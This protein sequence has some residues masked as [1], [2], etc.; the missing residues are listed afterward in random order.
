M[1]IANEAPILPPGHTFYWD[2]GLLVLSRAFSKTHKLLIQIELNDEVKL[3]SELLMAPNAAEIGKW[4][5]AQVINDSQNLPSREI[6][7]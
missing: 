4:L 7:K 2:D 5:E 6:E 1:I 3:L